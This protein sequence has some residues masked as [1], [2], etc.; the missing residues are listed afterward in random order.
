MVIQIYV[1][2]IRTFL[3]TVNYIR[4]NFFENVQESNSEFEKIV[5]QLLKCFYNH[6][7]N[8]SPSP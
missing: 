2:Q 3:F 6:I 4:D 5:I 8:N 7:I 1:F